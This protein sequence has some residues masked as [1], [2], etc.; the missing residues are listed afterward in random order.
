MTYTVATLA[1][2]LEEQG[3]PTEQPMVRY[4]LKSR[5]I[6]ATEKVGTSLVYDDSVADELLEIVQNKRRPGRKANAEEVAEKPKR[7]TR[8]KAKPVEDDEDE[9]EAPAKPARKRPA[10][11]KQAA[12]AAK[13]AA[14]ARK[15]PAKKQE[16]EDDFD[17]LDF[18][19]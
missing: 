18:D 12:P 5:G 6:E 2:H 15:R 16:P 17:D 9:D 10:A 8:A 1:E 19:E 11:K 3:F 7:K 4:F 14:P 13:K